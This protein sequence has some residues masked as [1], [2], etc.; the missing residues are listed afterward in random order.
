MNDPVFGEWMRGIYASPANPNRYGMYVRTIYIP[1]GRM[2][3]GK[4]YE[5]TNGLGAF[6]VYPVNSV[7]RIR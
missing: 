7:E 6:W 3:S 5:I 2:N 4:H 1:R